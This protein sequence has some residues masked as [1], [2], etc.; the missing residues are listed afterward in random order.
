MTGV[1]LARYR[2]QVPLVGAYALGCLAVS[3]ITFDTLAGVVLAPVAITY[4]AVWAASAI[5]YRTRVDLSYGT[6]LLAFPIT[7]ILLEAGLPG[8]VAHPG[9]DGRR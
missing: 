8:T 6:Y 5:R 9:R 1:A 7:Q 2:M 3:V 4:T